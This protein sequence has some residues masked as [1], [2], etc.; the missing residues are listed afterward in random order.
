MTIED[1]NIEKWGWKREGGIAVPHWMT[2][3]EAS[4]A[5]KELIKCC[6]KTKC[7]G[8]CNCKKSNVS[9]TELCNCGG[10]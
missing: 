2:Q 3:P 9:C 8:R 6:C 10:C 5:C 7:G 1:E 4:Q